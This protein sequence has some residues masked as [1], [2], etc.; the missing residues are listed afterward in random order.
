MTEPL[1]LVVNAALCD[2]HGICA[3]RCPE[4][5]T[6]DEWGFAAVEDGVV[7]EGGVLRRARR[8]V[9][10]C[11]RRALTLVAQ[12]R[13]RAPSPQPGPRLVA[14]AH[15]GEDPGSSDSKGPARRRRSSHAGG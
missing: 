1:R 13:S 9:A 2:G 11:P 15:P 8:A 7:T 12:E 5:V 3:L 4:L 10:A 14:L 6:L